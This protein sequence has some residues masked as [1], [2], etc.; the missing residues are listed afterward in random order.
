MGDVQC[1][2]RFSAI[3]IK[4]NIGHNQEFFQKVWIITHC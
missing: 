3:F 2:W 4:K 1:H